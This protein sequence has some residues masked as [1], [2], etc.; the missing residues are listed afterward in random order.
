MTRSMDI[1]NPPE[2]RSIIQ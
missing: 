2:Q 1:E